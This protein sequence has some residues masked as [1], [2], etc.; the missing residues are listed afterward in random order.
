[1][2]AATAPTQ[3]VQKAIVTLH[4]ARGLKAADADFKSDPYVVVKC[5]L[6][7]EKTKVSIIFFI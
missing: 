1:M 2:S 4:E 3:T 7:Y 5:G 6:H